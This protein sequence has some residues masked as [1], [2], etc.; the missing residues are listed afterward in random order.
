MYNRNTP[1]QPLLI[2]MCPSYCEAVNSVTMIMCQCTYSLTEFRSQIF[3]VLSS[4]A[5]TRRLESEDQATSD[6]PYR[7]MR[8]IREICTYT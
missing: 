5:D 7:H 1:C 2:F 6:I 8:V 4:D 3:R